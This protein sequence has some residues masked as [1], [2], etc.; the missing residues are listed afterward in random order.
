[1]ILDFTLRFKHTSSLTQIVCVYT[2]NN[3]I[4]K[5]YKIIKTF[6]VIMLTSYKLQCFYYV[7]NLNETENRR[8]IY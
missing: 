2:R 6:C 5:K 1:M 8:E 3:C 4:F 7:F